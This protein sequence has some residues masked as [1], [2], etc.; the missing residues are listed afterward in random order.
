MHAVLRASLKL[1][2]TAFARALQVIILGLLFLAMPLSTMGQHF[3]KV[4]GE[5]ELWKLQALVRQLLTENDLSPED[6]HEAFEQ[7]DADGDGLIDAAEFSKCVTQTLGLK[8]PKAS[9]LSLW[10]AFDADGSGTVTIEEFAEI[11][12][13]WVHNEINTELIRGVT[14]TKTVRSSSNMNGDNR[15]GSPAVDN[16]RTFS[17]KR[18]NSCP[19]QGL[20][21]L[22]VFEVAGCGEV[23][24][25]DASPKPAV[26]ERRASQRRP[27]IGGVSFAGERD[28]GSKTRERDGGSNG[29][30]RGGSRGSDDGDASL[31]SPLGQRG[32]SPLG[33][34]GTSPLGQ[35]GMSP[36]GGQRGTSPNGG[37]RDT[38]PNGLPGRN[39][40]ERRPSIASDDGSVRSLG[41]F[42]SGGSGRNLPINRIKSLERRLIEHA[43]SSQKQIGHLSAS[44]ERLCEQIEHLGGQLLDGGKNGRSPTRRGK[45]TRDDD[46]FFQR[47]NGRSSGDGPQKDGPARLYS[48]QPSALEGV[49]SV[50]PM[51]DRAASIDSGTP[52]EAVEEEAQQQEEKDPTTGRPMTLEERLSSA[53]LMQTQKPDEP[54]PEDQSFKALL[55]STGLF[56]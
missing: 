44:V 23:R 5:R 41:S 34:R 9:L 16:G 2:C 7:F 31:V 20:G 36:N 26:R 35:R 4:W 3:N 37:Q 30:I 24:E 17:K 8:L 47:A 50:A 51:C 48:R 22:S 42:N 55:K 21:G 13:P 15:S 19:G 54:Q 14:K 45:D 56:A 46:S 52:T 43:A 6:F 40:R 10:R 12:F 33:Q 11:L 28:S 1:P 49:G 29:G 32:T 27:S 39:V 38:S 53:T 18:R 25:R